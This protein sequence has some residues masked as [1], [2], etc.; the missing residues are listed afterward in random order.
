MRRLPLSVLL[1]AALAILTMVVGPAKASPGEG[2]L[3]QGRDFQTPTP[4]PDGTIIYIV[5]EGDALWTIAALSG[6]TVEELMA[7][8]GLQSNDIISPGMELILGKAGPPGPTQAPGVLSSPTPAQATP[9]P[10]FGAGEICIMVFLDENGN[11]RLDEGEGALPQS[12]V[13]VA[14]SDGV[15]AGEH[16]TDDNPEGHCFSDLENGDY[17]VSAAVPPGYNP[18]TSMNTPIRLAPGDIKNV[19]FGAQ[20]SAALRDPGPNRDGGRSTLL[21]LLGVALL[22]AAGGLAYYASK[23]GR[24]KPRSLR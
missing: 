20:P 21:G 4:G 24:D 5:Q 12:Q 9:T 13:S 23:Y 22:V 8:N 6:V 18:T 15:L 11:A 16:T 14:D 3:P 10:I 19:Q 1:I 17:N 7:L 2:P